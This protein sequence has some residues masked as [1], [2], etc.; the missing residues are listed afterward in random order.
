MSYDEG[1]DS[2]MSGSNQDKVGMPGTEGG[3]VSLP[4]IQGASRGHHRYYVPVPASAHRLCAQGC[5]E[6]Q[7]IPTP[8]APEE[9]LLPRPQC[10]D[11]TACPRRLLSTS[12][13]VGC[14]GIRWSH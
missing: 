6:G 7:A 14:T 10:K 2:E 13:R 5:S 12:R 8:P 11:V 3:S 9:D 4:E 1:L